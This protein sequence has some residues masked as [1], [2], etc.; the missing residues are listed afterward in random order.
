MMTPD[1]IEDLRRRA[2]AS[3]MNL[4]EADEFVEAEIERRVADDAARRLAD[5][6]AKGRELRAS[7][8]RGQG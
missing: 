1:E 3:G 4:T 5:L 6:V 7:V 8:G 2:M